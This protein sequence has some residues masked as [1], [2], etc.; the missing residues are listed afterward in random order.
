MLR[1]KVV[2]GR[3]KTGEDGWCGRW[4]EYVRLPAPGISPRPIGL[5]AD[6]VVPFGF[7]F[8][9]RSNFRI[10]TSLLLREF[11]FIWTEYRRSM[12]FLRDD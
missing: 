4:V 11:Q 9:V 10:D 5:I 8:S 3:P 12:P 6:W 7:L 2:D 1:S